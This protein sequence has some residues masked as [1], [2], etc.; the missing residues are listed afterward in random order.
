MADG[1]P[2]QGR[3]GAT[4]ITDAKSGASS[5]L[6]SREKRYAITMAF[7]TACFICMVFVPGAFR[8]VLFAG[9]VF[10]PYV[11][12]VLANQTNS[13]SDRA[14][15]IQRGEPEPAPQLTSGPEEPDVIIGDV[16][17]DHRTGIERVTAIEHDRSV[18]W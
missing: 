15:R 10:L 5:D 4:V 1:N 14:G 9:A 17:V 7:R 3:S 6:S 18:R 16:E 8:W 11:A 12:V 2:S 13:R